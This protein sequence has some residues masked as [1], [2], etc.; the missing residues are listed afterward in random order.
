MSKS[1][2]TR[3]GNWCVEYFVGKEM[4]NLL[5]AMK[6][7]VFAGKGKDHAGEGRKTNSDDLE[8]L[9]DNSPVPEP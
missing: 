7:A 9:H 3:Y 2:N 1:A 6:F 4:G 8:R 5:A